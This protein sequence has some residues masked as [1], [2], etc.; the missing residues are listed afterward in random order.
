MQKPKQVRP[1]RITDSKLRRVSLST[2]Q[3]LFSE[4]FELNE[5]M[6]ALLPSLSTKYRL[7]LITQV[8]SENGPEHQKVKA[9]LKNLKGLSEHRLMFCSTSKGKEAMVRQLGAEL[10]KVTTQRQA[11]LTSQ[12]DELI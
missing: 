10:H 8:P 7:F 9:L 5:Q 4:S 3:I 2:N 12:G 6:A 11:L 1:P